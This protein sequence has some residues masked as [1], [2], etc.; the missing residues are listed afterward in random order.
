MQ[1]KPFR[2]LF[3]KVHLI[4]SPTVFC[5]DAK[6][7]F[8]KYLEED[9]FERCEKDGFYVYQIEN[10]IHKHIGLIGLNHIQDF[11]EGNIRKHEETLSEKE[12]KQKELFIRWK[13]I[14]K[15][16]LVA[17]APVPG[18][19]SWLEKYAHTHLPI[20]TMRFKKEES[21][22]RLWQVAQPDD[23]D[24]LQ[25]F[26]AGN[27]KKTYIADGHHRT[28]TSAMLYL[29]PE[30]QG[31]GLDFSH[32]FCAWF[33]ADQL[34]ILDYNRVIEGVKNIGAARLMALLSKVF[35]I[36]WLE[37]PRKPQKKHELVA[38]LGKEWYAM[39][40]RTSVLESASKG[41]DTLDTALLNELVIND[42]FG[43]KDVRTDTRIIYV[44]GSKGLQG[45][46]KVAKTKRNDKIGFMFYPVDFQDMAVLADSGE[47]LPPKSTYFEP[48]LKSG[49]M[50]RL[51]DQ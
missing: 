35:E 19:I 28:T 6:L 9:L 33:S 44:E 31:R 21:I 5:N 8:K 42:I 3:P 27:V 41:Y 32:L 14:L 1:I 29:D 46:Q 12:L 16:V 11:L 13:A 34:D 30:M 18:L 24:F 22:H 20:V 51:L 45:V 49:L 26:Y 7:S 15:P 47:S 38:C 48:R 40:W 17:H 2:A 43:I 37:K 23:L 4:D 10:G 50:V 39:Q 36:E 25:D